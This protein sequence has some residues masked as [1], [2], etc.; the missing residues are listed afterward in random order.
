MDVEHKKKQLISFRKHLYAKFIFNTFVIFANCLKMHYFSSLIYT[1][2]LLYACFRIIISDQ[3]N[4]TKSNYL[5][6]S[7]LICFTLMSQG[8]GAS[9]QSNMF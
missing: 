9:L 7:M 3:C 4:D 2:K 6:Y 5:G 8:F 1:P